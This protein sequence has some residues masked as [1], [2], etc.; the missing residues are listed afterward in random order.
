[1]RDDFAALGNTLSPRQE[2]DFYR[3]IVRFM[4]FNE[5]FEESSPKVDGCL[6]SIETRL[7]LSKANAKKRI[8]RS[9][10]TDN[11]PD[12][13]TDNKTDNKPDNKTDNKPD[14]KTVAPLLKN[15]DKRLTLGKSSLPVTLPNLQQRHGGN[16]LEG[17]SPAL[18]VT[19]S[20]WESMTVTERLNVFSFMVAGKSSEPQDDP[21]IPEGFEYPI[22]FRGRPF[23]RI[24]LAR[25]HAE[26]IKQAGNEPSPDG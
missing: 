6:K 18:P 19:D 25:E 7:K 16:P 11:K 14:N 12:N 10:K 20:Q 21:T 9:N 17:V 8:G 13:K 2:G 24:Q 4:L 5:E 3:A 26:L 1:M 23:S 15:R 22:D